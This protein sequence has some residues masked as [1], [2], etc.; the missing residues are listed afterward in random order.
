MPKIDYCVLTV[1]GNPTILQLL[2]G[3]RRLQ[4]GST[5]PFSISV[6]PIHKILKAAIPSNGCFCVIVCSTKI[7][8]INDNY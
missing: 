3:R 7:L 8:N 5:V 2:A 1:A 4:I 6:N